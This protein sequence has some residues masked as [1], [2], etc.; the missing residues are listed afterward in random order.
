MDEWKTLVFTAI[1]Q[2]IKK[3]IRVFNLPKPTSIYPTTHD[4]I[5]YYFD[6]LEKF[7]LE[8]SKKI[9]NKLIEIGLIRNENDTA[10][11]DDIYQ[12]TKTT[13]FTKGLTTLTNTL[14]II[15]ITDYIKIIT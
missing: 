12:M 13:V 9:K 7:T 5:T 3:D 2:Y 8:T 14:G 10:F 1:E 15:D 11:D 4:Y 6:E